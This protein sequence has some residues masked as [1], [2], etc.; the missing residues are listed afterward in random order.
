DDRCPEAPVY[1]MEGTIAERALVKLEPLI[2]SRADLEQSPSPVVK[3][4]VARGVRTGCLAP[5]V[6]HGRALGVISMVSLRDGAFTAEDAELLTQIAGQIAIAVE[7]ALN[8]ERARAAE[9][10]AKRE[11]NR[12]Q[13][14]LDL[15]K[16][17]VSTLDLL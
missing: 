2:G 7:N 12:V 9:A 15:N 11:S 4:I 16:A 14:L 6:S 3:R 5:L 1:S 13:L 10:T 17:V 8:F